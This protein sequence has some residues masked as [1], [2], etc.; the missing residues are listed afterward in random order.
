MV[1]ITDIMVRCSPALH[2]GADRH[3]TTAA[4]GEMRRNVVKCDVALTYIKLKLTI[5]IQGGPKM[6]QFFWL[7]LT[8]SNINR[9]S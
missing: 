7:A 2:R 4:D 9:F 3:H 1:L 6:A 5:D 8:S